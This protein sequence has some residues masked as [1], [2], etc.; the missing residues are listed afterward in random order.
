MTSTTNKM[1]T[2]KFS[3]LFLTTVLLCTYQPVM[4]NMKVRFVESAPKDWFS[5][6]N[7]GECVLNK[8]TMT[9]DL[10]NTTGKL[11]FD[12]TSAGAGVEVFQ[13]FEKREGEIELSSAKKVM[14]GENT[15]SVLINS[16]AP[17]QSISFTIDVDDTL[18]KSELGNIRVSGAE[19]AGGTVNLA[20]ADQQKLSGTFDKKAE[21]N[22]PSPDC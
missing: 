9:V 12:T 20:F 5:L 8:V 2:F 16:I 3:S 15:L 6:T 17:G 13:P 10:S 7:D 18:T 4:A 14:D 19:I 22:L 1:H 21:I 11:I